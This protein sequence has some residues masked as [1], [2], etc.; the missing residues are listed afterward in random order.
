LNISPAQA[1]KFNFNV[2]NTF[3]STRICLAIAIACLL[4][5]GAQTLI[6]VAGILLI[7][8]ATTDF[9]DGF[10]ARRLGQ[11]SLFGSLFDIVADQVLFMPALIMAITNGLFDRVN[12]LFI[13]NPYLYAVPALTGG[14]TVLG[15]V[16]IFLIKSRK[17][18]MVFPTPTGVAKV[19]Y[20]FW[21]AP[22]ILAVLNIGPDILLAIL[23]YLAVISTILTFYSYLRKGSY[24]FT[25]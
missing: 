7:I 24:V 17:R 8:A 13:L 11:T 16:A 14:V 22:L 1:I 5:T 21:L 4:S 23:M 2:P 20:W 12:G 3:T 18:P 25:D 19:N 15:G 6:F 10:L 9:F